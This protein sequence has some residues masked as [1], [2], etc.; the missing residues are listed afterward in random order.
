MRSRSNETERWGMFRDFAGALVT[1]LVGT[2]NHRGQRQGEEGER[3]ADQGLAP[4][5]SQ[6]HG[7]IRPRGPDQPASK[8][9]EQL[10]RSL[11]P[12]RVALPGMA[13]QRAPH[14][15]GHAQV[16]TIPRQVRQSDGLAA[17]GVS[18]Q[19]SPIRPLAAH[20]VHL[21]AGLWGPDDGR[22]YVR[23]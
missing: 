9:L 6:W 12:L 21:K 19:A 7:P 14:P 13:D 18:V 2:L 20:R 5:P 23:S 3:Q 17:E 11:L 15:V 8:G 22:L 1:D 16:Q 10:L 4:Q